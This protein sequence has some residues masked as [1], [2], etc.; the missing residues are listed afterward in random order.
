MSLKIN[1]RLDLYEQKINEN[2]DS[3]SLNKILEDC[4]LIANK[5]PKNSKLFYL[6]GNIMW[7]KLE[8]ENA[9]NILKEVS[10]FIN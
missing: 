5:Y 1:K 7:T 4:Y 8:L 3:E 10:S 9:I 6:I 2:L